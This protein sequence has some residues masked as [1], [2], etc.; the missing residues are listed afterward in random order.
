MMLN[1]RPA[2]IAAPKAV[3]MVHSPLFADL[4]A[5]GGGGAATA[6]PPPTIVA[7]TAD[8]GCCRMKQ[9][10]ASHI[11][12]LTVPSSLTGPDGASGFTCTGT[13][14]VTVPSHTFSVPSCGN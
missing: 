11:W 5:G 6:L 1:A 14:T 4:I 7:P 8:S 13:C 10:L 2:R 3:Q 12:Y 9:D